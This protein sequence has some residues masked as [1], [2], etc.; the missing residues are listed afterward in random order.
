MAQFVSYLEKNVQ[1]VAYGDAP[2]R[3]VTGKA[4]MLYDGTWNA[5]AIAALDPNF[6]FGYFPVPGDTNA[7]PNQLQGKYDMQFNIAAK[8]PN[9][10]VGL[11][12][13]TFLSQKENYTP[14]VSALG[15]FP[16]MPGVTSTSA[17]VASIA[18]KNKNFGM[19]LGKIHLCS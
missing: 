7:N 12:W 18:D 14:F 8:S 10:D 5:G 16:T 9:K 11:K 1:A 15:F 4:A 19:A 6:Q 17:F 2:G 13:F 3:L